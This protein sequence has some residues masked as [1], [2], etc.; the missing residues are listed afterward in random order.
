[1]PGGATLSLHAIPAL[2]AETS[3]PALTNLSAEVWHALIHP[4]VAPPV[5]GWGRLL[6]A[7]LT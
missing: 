5:H 1:M 6:A 7:D 2:E 3:K 4:G